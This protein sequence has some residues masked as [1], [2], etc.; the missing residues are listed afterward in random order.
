MSPIHVGL[1]TVIYLANS[2]EDFLGTGATGGARPAIF[3]LT[4]ARRTSV[5]A[6][7]ASHSNCRGCAALW[8]PCPHLAR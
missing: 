1:D 7:S 4:L 8:E 5:Y 2:G 6:T 3:K